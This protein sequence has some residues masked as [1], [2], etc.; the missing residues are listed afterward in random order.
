MQVA[1]F[2][3][4][5]DR[6]GETSIYYAVVLMFIVLGWNCLVRATLNSVVGT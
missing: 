2:P 5:I 6:V 3:L 4:L 1:R